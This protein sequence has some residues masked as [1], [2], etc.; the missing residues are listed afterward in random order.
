MST[1]W[2]LDPAH[3]EISFKV[4]HMMISNVKGEFKSFDAE[5]I[6]ENETFTNA[7][8][9]STIQVDSVNT[10]NTDRDNHLKSADFFD[11]E[12]NPTIQFESTSLNNEVA[13][14]ITIN[15]ITQPIVLEVEFNG[16][17]VDPWGN[18]RA[19][20]SFTGKIKRKDFNLNWNAALDSGGVVVGETVNIS[21]ELEFI[22]G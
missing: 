22:K 1:T 9:Q 20:F 13:G 6:S 21:G 17:Q 3:S 12:K 4:K 11:V 2:K 19:G 15:G 18:T 14:K 5:I 7:K 8:V 16:I 10:N